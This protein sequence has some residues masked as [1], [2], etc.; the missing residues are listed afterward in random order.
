MT[1]EQLSGFTL[2]ELLVTLALFATI[3]TLLLGSFVQLQNQDAKISDIL[4]MRQEARILEKI[5]RHD[6]QSAVYLTEYMWNKKAALDDRQSGIV[7]ISNEYD[8]KNRDLVHMH[9]HKASEFIRTIKLSEDP[10][11]QEVTYYI[12]DTEEDYLQFQR[13]EELY[14]DNDITEGD[15]SITHTLSQHV[16]EFDIQFYRGIESEKIEEWDSESEV[17]NKRKP[18]P[19]GVEVTLVYQYD[20][21]AILKTSFQII[22]QPTTEGFITWKN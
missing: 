18:I 9:V 4:K 17:K 10:E 6:F 5:I 8:N 14:V 1:K 11:V 16:T 12:D 15:Q 13:R 22:L 3:I 19:A 20:S 21:G 7:S 2:L